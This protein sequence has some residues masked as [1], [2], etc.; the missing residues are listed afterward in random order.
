VNFGT[1]V[2]IS[3]N[4]T[5]IA[6]YHTTGTYVATNNYFTNAVTSGP[7][8]A[9]SNATAG[10]NG[11]YA[12]GGSA[13]SG[14]YPNATYGSSNYWVDV[15]F[16]T[17]SAPA[18]T[19]PTAVAD[20]GDATEKGGV[21]NGSG[22][23]AATG[24]VLTNDTDPD[25]GDT[26]TV[27]AV[28]FGATAGTLGT[29]LNGT[30]GSLV[31][32]AA[33]TYTYTINE[34][35]AAVQ[36]LRLSTNTLSEVF[37][38]TMRDTAGA[39]ASSTLTITIHG[40]NDAPVLAAQTA[41]QNATVGTAFSLVLP[42][43]TFT[44]VD[45][46]DT[47][48]YT[49][50]LADGSV[51]PSW[52]SFNAA[53]RTFSGT[54]TAS[55]TI[56]VRVTATDLGGLATSE[57]FNIAVSIPGNATPTAVADTGD[58]TEKGGI[59]NG[60]GGVAATGNVLTNDTDP[61]S[62]DTKTVSA[63]SFGATAGTLG[64]ALN[65]T[66]GSLVL[67][68]A[69]TYTYTIN[70]SN[71]A[72]Q[73]LRLSTNT[74]SEVF[75]YTMRDTAGATASSTLT[76]TIH[77]ANDAPVLAAQTAAQNATVG[78]AF[79]LVLP[80]NTFTDVDTGDTLT[81]SS[82]LADG[83]ALPS[84]LSFNAATRTFTGTPTASGTTSVRVTATDLGGLATSETFNIA[85]STAPTTYSLF[86]AANT[87]AQTNLNDGSQLELGIKFQ[88][89]V[90]GTITGIKFYRS[91]NDNGQNVV[92]LWSSTGTKLATATYSGTTG[93]GWQ[94]VNFGTAVAISANTTYIASYH[95]TGTYVATDGYFTNSVSNGPLTAMSSAL[96][97]GN[98]VYAYGGSAT[99]G[100]FPNSTYD[101]ANYWADV[102]F[103]PQLAA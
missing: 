99:S 5:Y 102:V 35:N 74:L 38:Y 78:T 12:Y 76:I 44:D 97:G 57:T 56:G 49:S 90:A 53:T 82:T 11:V 47:L 26:K 46:G 33:G 84:W 23:V 17:G 91:A 22:G 13:T 64:A 19:V 86:T 20:S 103:K 95:T 67:N 7:L 10:G 36:A 21:A 27:S 87:P 100:I 37:N 3:A 75:N 43:N 18:N 66:Y 15:V 98:G 89:N 24:N 28:S 71:A 68:A 31:L 50:T 65:G 14:V 29:A 45:T 41:A 94:T 1:A 32:N 6:S 39:T 2:A 88:S 9:M 25:S 96:A 51:L 101:S 62:G 52:L 63:V 48:T 54:P 4:T 70:E 55:G 79:S 81:Y 42:A 85:V 73:A 40:A 80:A 59:A 72:V 61:D 16:N 92:D 8:T 60:S 34:S 69:G 30:Y 58:A 93:S 77:G 83:S